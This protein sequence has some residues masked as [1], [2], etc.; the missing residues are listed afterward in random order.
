[1]NSGFKNIV[2]GDRKI[3]YGEKPFLIAEVAQTHDG[4]LGLAHAFI[5]AA[6]QAGADAIKFQTH[7]ADAE[8]TPGEPFRIA[9]SYEDKSRYDYWKRME[10]SKDGWRGLIEHAQKCGLIFLSSPFSLEAVA[11]LDEL[12]MPAWK[13]G[14][15]EVNNP[16]MLK[17]ILKTKKPVLLSSGMSSYEE[18]AEA[19]RLVQETE[20]PLALFQCTSQ[21]PSPL[22]NVG[23]NVI[24]ELQ[25]KHRVPVGLSDHSG[26]IYP[27]LAA[28][29]QGANLVEVHVTLHKKM[30]GP[31][32]SVSL[33]FDELE[34]LSKAA[35][36]F[37]TMAKNPVDKNRMSR[38][39]EG[40]RKL[41]N[42][43]VALKQ[44]LKAGT[45]LS[46]DMLTTK[47]PGTG[48]PAQD[49]EKCIGKVLK[50]DVSHDRVLTW[51]DI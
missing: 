43:S 21:Y 26:Q 48:I 6:A 4:S 2:I 51:E 30:F 50:H 14:S 3:G 18:I 12:G 16:L 31:D 9:F 47:K 41:F 34:L 39:M 27:A 22:E 13:I 42:K 44:P 36:A 46:Q 38:E 5:E 10:F 25:D 33:T 49:L 17:A 29:A 20:S 23:L 40:M 37:H 19:V 28:M 1:M 8:S 45:K 24:R 7:I 32:V 35:K 15:G 11:M